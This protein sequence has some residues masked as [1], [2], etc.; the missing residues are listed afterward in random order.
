MPYPPVW[1]MWALVLLNAACLAD[2][3]T[4]TMDI[5]VIKK[6]VKTAVVAAF[7]VAPAGVFAQSQDGE[8]AFADQRYGWDDEYTVSTKVSR[9]GIDTEFRVMY[10]VV[11]NHGKVSVCGVTYIRSR[12]LRYRES[13]RKAFK[14]M[15]VQLNGKSILKDVSFFTAT[16]NTDAFDYASVACQATDIDYPSDVNLSIRID[17]RMF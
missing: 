4:N 11:N 3:S 17:K 7:F 1:D 14:E 6:I 12:G 13:A 16:Y 2:N 9:S 10:G 5:F 15:R 8:H